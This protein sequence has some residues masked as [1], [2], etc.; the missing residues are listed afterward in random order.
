MTVWQCN[1]Q[2]YVF[3]FKVLLTDLSELV[4]TG[5]QI[6]QKSQVVSRGAQRYLV[7]RRTL[8][9]LA[10]VGVTEGL[11]LRRFC[12]LPVN[13]VQPLWVQESQNK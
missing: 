12:T 9:A 1:S 4:E 7:Q 3:L 6:V 2:L 5:P 13:G 8:A 10:L 11:V